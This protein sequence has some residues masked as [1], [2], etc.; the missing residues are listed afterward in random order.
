MFEMPPFLDEETGRHFWFIRQGVS[1]GV[2]THLHLL[3]IH[4]YNCRF[5]LYYIL[6]FKYLCIFKDNLVQILP[7][8]LIK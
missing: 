5:Y 8:T 3:C 4:L 7:H 1:S 6:T 2:I